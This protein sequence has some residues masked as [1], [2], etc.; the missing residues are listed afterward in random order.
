MA[1]TSARAMARTSGSM[2]PKVEDA[3]DKDSAL[4]AQSPAAMSTSM[5]YLTV[6]LHTV[7]TTMDVISEKPSHAA[8]ITPRH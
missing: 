2:L 6:K 3:K 8:M 1:F 5:T 4:E 7:H